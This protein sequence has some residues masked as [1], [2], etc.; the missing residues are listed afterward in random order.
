MPYYGGDP[1][2]NFGES[3]GRALA[4]YFL[5]QKARRDE[6][7]Q[8][9]AGAYTRAQ[10]TGDPTAMANVVAGASPQAIQEF[11]AKTGI[12]LTQYLPQQFLQMPQGGLMN[13]PVPTGQ[14]IPPQPVT[15]SLAPPAQPTLV[16][17]P[18]PE[19]P[20]P[21]TREGQL[22]RAEHEER[23]MPEDWQ[24]MNRFLRE[25]VNMPEAYRKLAYGTMYKQ[26]MLPK[27]WPEKPPEEEQKPSRL[28]L[29]QFMQMY[30]DRLRGAD[31]WSAYTRHIQEGTLPSV[32]PSLGGEEKGLTPAMW[33]NLYKMY[34]DMTE[35]EKKQLQAWGAA[36]GKEPFPLSRPPVTE[37][38]PVTK[39]LVDM[40]V[41]LY[42]SMT[43]EERAQTSVPTIAQSLAQGDIKGLE[44]YL[45]RYA[46][47]KAQEADIRELI[48]M[49]S[50]IPAGTKDK[51]LKKQREDYMRKL[52]EYW[53][54]PFTEKN[55]NLLEKIIRLFSQAE[56]APED[57][58]K[59]IQEIDI[60]D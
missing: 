47:M 2:G 23:K 38:R 41:G 27:S 54:L 21:T 4:A 6:A 45:E 56:Q 57:L 50:T 3:L 33:I 19:V 39:S 17:K 40:A 18:Q 24:V 58:N 12:D 20:W 1:F 31:L 11:Q 30:G 55:L 13:V 16:P 7:L 48:K 10:A 44:P 59:A 15:P 42:N 25:Y 43:P 8:T 60:N 28:T 29:Y 5:A 53:G 14:V 34:P 49:L 22:V 52:A 46:Q 51:K 26:G 32:E 35:E 37:P 9:L 36:G